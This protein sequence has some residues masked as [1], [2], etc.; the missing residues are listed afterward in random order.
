MNRRQRDRRAAFDAATHAYAIQRAR[1]MTRDEVVQAALI[2][3]GPIPTTCQKCAQRPPN[4]Y[5]M[6]GAGAWL[7]RPCAGLEP[8]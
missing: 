5:Q 8:L 3:L 4:T 2:R 1:A 7:C 6:T